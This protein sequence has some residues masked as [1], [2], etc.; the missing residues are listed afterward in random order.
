[1]LRAPEAKAPLS[2]PRWFSFHSPQ[3]WWEVRGRLSETR[4]QEVP[5]F[6]GEAL[7][8]SV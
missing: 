8:A 7:Q 6:W 5:G 4:G 2:P 1:M 3:P